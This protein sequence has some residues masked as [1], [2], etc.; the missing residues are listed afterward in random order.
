MLARI[1]SISAA[2]L[3]L[4]AATGGRMHAQG[5]T[6]ETLDP[7][8]VTGTPEG[9]PR[10]RSPSTVI[11]IDEEQIKDVS[12]KS[13]SDLLGV[14]GAAF[15]N[16]WTP[17]QSQINMRGGIGDSQGRDYKSQVMVLVNGRRGGTSNL[18]KLSPN[19]V[20]RVEVMRGP[21]S[22]MFG[23]Q[24]I[25]GIINIITRNGRNTQGGQIDLKTG[26]AKMI[27]T[28]AHYAG[29]FDP[30][31]KL[32]GY[33]GGFW[34]DKG[35]YRGG[36]GAGKELNTQ[37][38]R[39]GGLANL[40]WRVNDANSVSFTA[41][42][43]GV[44]NVGFRGSSAAYYA[45]DD[46]MNHSMDLVWESKPSDGFWE[47][48]L[49]NYMGLDQDYT[50]WVTRRTGLL[51]DHNKRKYFFVGSKFQPL[52]HLSDSND[53][54]AGVDFEYNTLRSVRD[55]HYT[56]GRVTN[57]PNDLN[58]SEKM[59]AFYLEDTHRMF[60]QRF[61][62]RA[63]VRHT[64]SW[65]SSDPTPD[66]GDQTL[67]STRFDHTTWSVGL[68][69]IVNDNLSLRAGAATGFRSPV[70]SEMTG[71]SSNYNNPAQRYIGNPD[72]NPE[73]SLEY[74][75]GMYAHGRG[76]FAD[77]A[78][79]HNVIKD[80]IT[81]TRTPNMDYFYINNPGR[82]VASGI[83]F[84]SRLNVDELTDL[85]GFKLAFGLY[86]SYNFKM[87]DEA[88]NRD[89]TANTNKVERMYQ[90]QGSIFAQLGAGRDNPWS[91]RL[92][93]VYKGHVWYRT[94]EA[95]RVPQDE[96]RSD[97]IHRKDP[98]WLLNFYGEV[99]ISD[100]FTIYGGVDNIT[101]KN[102]HPMLIA[103]DDGTPYLN[104]TNG[105]TGT[106]NPGREFYLGVKYGF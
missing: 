36:R 16:D 40:D 22:V 58:Q 14:Y 20:Y 75:G 61:S 47:F 68:N 34:N 43:D 96:P 50:G 53:L 24:A 6:P 89:A 32:A 4:S 56:Y 55:V 51:M 98:I 39:Y 29:N 73:T 42:S 37:W 3:I 65:L 25:G 106:S 85:N 1:V 19:D 100:S 8:T 64:L 48:R 49:H 57:S 72:I 11:I 71:W 28:H 88:K 99:A 62:V 104:P 30:E 87:E 9:E 31:G 59:L 41:R 2:V 45:N 83:E 54:R 67:G 80:R 103:I 35:D 74:E 27:Y 69:L 15:F 46:R 97:W 21:N 81:T 66:M 70:A 84:G 95:L 91:V 23:S 7:V 13:M 82:I 79:Y 10:H 78:I 102:Y 38:T 76:W 33:F 12:A 94:E 92:T 52:F 63:G 60:D 17:G 77:L 105:G 18:M 86:G 26:S 5:A 93:G 101:D 90:S 44:Y